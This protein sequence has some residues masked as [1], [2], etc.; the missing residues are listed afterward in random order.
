VVE[1]ASG[2]TPEEEAR[3]MQQRRTA[4]STSVSE[5]FRI[6]VRRGSAQRTANHLKVVGH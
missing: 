6:E 3:F 2:L 1:T 5:A 4:A